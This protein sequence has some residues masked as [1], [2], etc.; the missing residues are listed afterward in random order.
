MSVLADEN[1]PIAWS[2]TLMDTVWLKVGVAVRGVVA[3]AETVPVKRPADPVFRERTC[4][5]APPS[6]MSEPVPEPPNSPNE[7]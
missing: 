6:A 1:D 3:V 2:S 7:V 4:V 5:L